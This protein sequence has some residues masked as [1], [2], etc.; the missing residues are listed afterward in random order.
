FRVPP[1]APGSKEFKVVENRLPWPWNTKKPRPQP[2]DSALL[3]QEI[4]QQ[5]T[6]NLD[7]PAL[8]KIDNEH[9][10]RSVRLDIRSAVEE[11]FRL[12]A[13]LLNLADRERLTEEVLDALFE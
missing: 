9:T 10:L 5:L 2:V 12:R 6:P 8:K 13:D 11:F 7:L 4:L 1:N 3:K